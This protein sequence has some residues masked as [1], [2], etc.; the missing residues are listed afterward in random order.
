[1]SE[2]SRGCRPMLAVAI[3]VM[4]GYGTPSI[5]AASF[6]ARPCCESAGYSSIPAS[7]VESLDPL[8]VEHEFRDRARDIGVAHQR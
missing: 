2:F 4:S 3:R 8:I 7:P 1:M 5:E 6:G